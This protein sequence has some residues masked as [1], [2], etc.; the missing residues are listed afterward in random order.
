MLKREQKILC[1]PITDACLDVRRNI[2]SIESTEIGNQ[3][4]AA[5]KNRLVG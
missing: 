4:V 2:G 5:T 3:C 1:P